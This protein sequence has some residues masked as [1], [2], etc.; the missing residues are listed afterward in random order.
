MSI[1]IKHLSHTYFK[2]TSLEVNTL[3]D[4]NL[5]IEDG[6][7]VGIMGQTGCGKTTLIQLIAGLIFPTDGQI[8]IDNED[9]N[10]KDYD[11]SIL[12][13]NVG[14]VFQYPEYQL[15]EATVEKDVAFALKHSGL[16]K[17]E[18][19]YKVESALT[20]MGFSYE[21]IKDESPLSL[22]GGE[23]RRVAIAGVLVMEPKILIFDEPIAGLDP[24]GRESFL[25]LIKDLNNKGAT[26]L[27]ISHHADSLC[28]YADRIIVLS[29][30]RIASDGTPKEIFSDIDKTTNLNIGTS[31]ARLVAQM[32]NERGFLISNDTITYDEL[33]NELIATFKGGDSV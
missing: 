18:I 20:L 30:G 2:G 21:K 1:E 25:K 6:E 14:V 29:N 13:K 26:I 10:K 28:E 19:K 9:I 23:K 4:I 8:L 7:F 5:Y 17:E 15:F 3:K 31:N 12:R 16:S 32:L 24:N 22:S 11:R 33:L 27:M